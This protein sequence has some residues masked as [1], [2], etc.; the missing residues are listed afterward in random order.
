MRVPAVDVLRGVC[1]VGILVMNIQSFAMPH[2]AY[3]NPKLFGSLAGTDGVAWGIGR[4]LFDFKFL[5]LFSMLFGASLVLGGSDT[6]PVRRLLWLVAF[7]LVHAYFIWYG[8]ILFTYG[9]VG[10]LLLRAVKWSPRR[11]LGVGAALLLVSPVLVA[12]TA[13]FL[14]AF[15]GWFTESITKHLD[16]RSVAAEV[17]AYRGGWLA[18]TPIRAAL[19]FE[20]QTFGLLLETGFRAAGCMLVGMAATRHRVFEGS[21][22]TW[23]WVPLGFALGIV[24][25]GAGMWLAWSQAFRVRPWLYAQALHELGAIPLSMAMGLLVIAVAN[26]FPDAAFVRSVADLGRVA[27]SAYLMHSVLGT[28]VF[29]GQGAGL[30]GTWSRTALLCAPFAVWLAQLVLARLWLR[31]FRVGPMEAMWRGLARGEFSLGRRAHPARD[32]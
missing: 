18:Q 20:S 9:V 31:R 15:P 4:L 23:P 30:F 13:A 1:L 17:A 14:D 29:G 19:S 6:R 8:D 24:I 22:P 12:L 26:R 2:A 28:W 5:S 10:L 7:G 3:L 21:V 11:Q 32:R 27:F 16:A 25:T